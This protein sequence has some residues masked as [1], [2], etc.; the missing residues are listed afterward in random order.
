MISIKE[1]EAP[2]VEL[3]I[4]NDQFD[5]NLSFI[6]NLKDLLMAA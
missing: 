5:Q 1:A 4:C 6:F 2:Y 3:W